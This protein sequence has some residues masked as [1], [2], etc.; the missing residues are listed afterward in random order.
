[1]GRIYYTLNIRLS[2]YK[3]CKPLKPRK[4]LTILTKHDSIAEVVFQIKTEV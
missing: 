4:Q 1:M 2:C 3:D